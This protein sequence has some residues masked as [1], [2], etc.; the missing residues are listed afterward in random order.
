VVGAA[1]CAAGF[2]ILRQTRNGRVAL[3]GTWRL[4]FL[5]MPMAAVAM[6]GF[7]MA[8]FGSVSAGVFAGVGFAVTMSLYLGVVSAATRLFRPN[9]AE[10]TQAYIRRLRSQPAGE[11]SANTGRF[12]SLLAQW[13]AARR[14]MPVSAADF[15]DQH[16]NDV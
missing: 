7:Y 4:I 13:R 9:R 2:L 14:E 3:A 15:L 16:W 5:V 10:F 6:S 8:I 11:S 12:S 1:V